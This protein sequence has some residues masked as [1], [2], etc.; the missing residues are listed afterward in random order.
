M[1]GLIQNL[2]FEGHLDYLSK[3][4]R[5]LNGTSQYN[6]LEVWRIKDVRNIPFI[7]LCKILFFI[8]YVSPGYSA[9]D[10]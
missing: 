5:L 10:A 7:S 2:R 3:G 1:A 4:W 9:R 8:A 6:I